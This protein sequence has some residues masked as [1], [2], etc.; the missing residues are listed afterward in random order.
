MGPF[1]GPA[2]EEIMVLT[3]LYFHIPNAKLLLSIESYNKVLIFPLMNILKFSL[4]IQSCQLQSLFGL[5]GEFQFRERT[6]SQIYNTLK[7]L[8]VEWEVLSC[9]KQFCRRIF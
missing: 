6:K 8:Q 7:P 9:Q 5:K 4:N 3:P 1:P 2:T